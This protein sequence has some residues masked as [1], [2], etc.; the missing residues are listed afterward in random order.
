[1]YKGVRIEFANGEE[2]IVPPLSLGSIELLQDD[3]DQFTGAVTKESVKTV[4]KAT[5]MALQRN[6]PEMSEEKVKNE[7]LD[8][9]NMMQVM[10]AVMDIGGLVRKE[11]EAAGE[12]QPRQ[13]AASA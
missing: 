5:L 12:A 10:Q 6:Y 8:V 3:L 9:G 2:Y 1:M 13:E 4:V 11:Q 7:L